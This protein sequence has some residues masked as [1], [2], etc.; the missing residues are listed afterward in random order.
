MPKNIAKNRPTYSVLNLI[1]I[2]LT[3][4]NRLFFSLWYKCGNI[5][6]DLYM[7][8]CFLVNIN[9]NNLRVTVY[10]YFIIRFAIAICFDKICHKIVQFLKN[11]TRRRRFI[12]F[13]Q[14]KMHCTRN[15]TLVTRYLFDM[16]FLCSKL[17]GH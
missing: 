2:F 17:I 9:F 3:D 7:H 6:F 8:I 5:C 1:F 16:F 12:K 13:L 14:H 10:F 11:N 4:R 15:L